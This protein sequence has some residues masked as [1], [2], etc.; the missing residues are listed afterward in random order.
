MTVQY[1]YQ[2]GIGGYPAGQETALYAT[3]AVVGNDANTSPKTLQSFAIPANLLANVGDAIHIYMAGNFAA[4]TDVKT[5]K[6]IINPGASGPTVAT[7][8]GSIAASTA[9]AADILILKTGSKTQSIQVLS[10]VVGA[11]GATGVASLTAAVDDTV[12]MTFGCV[13]QNA[14]TGT[15]NSVTCRTFI[16]S[17]RAAPGAQ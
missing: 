10:A 8:Q 1:Q 5:A 17:R 16:V 6:L 14:T 11:S 4:S 3:G 7:I 2:S 13:G 12:A 9:W 15:A